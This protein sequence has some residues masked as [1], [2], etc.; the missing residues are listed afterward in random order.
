HIEHWTELRGGVTHYFMAQE[1]IPGGSL[2][3]ALERGDRF[4]EARCRALALDL[5]E[6]LTYLHDLSPPV[7][8]RDIKPGNLML[9]PDGKCVLVDF[10]LVR[11]EARPGGGSTMAIGTIGYAPLEQLMGRALPATDLYALGATLVALLSRREPADLFDP[12]SHRLDFSEH[13]NVSPGFAAIL[14]RLLAPA[15]DDRFT[16][17]RQVK[18]ALR[19]LEQGQLALPP[20]DKA[21]SPA[22]SS[23]PMTIEPAALAASEEESFSVALERSSQVERQGEIRL[24]R[25]IS[26][27]IWQRGLVFGFA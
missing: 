14:E 8:H 2:A 15:V 24:A 21:S 13:V 1:F 26:A 4:D 5:L 25:S 22:R 9:R 7:I 3:Q 16:D 10:D 27:P 11:D 12:G 17:A 23:L 18:A 20:G 19:D 6:T